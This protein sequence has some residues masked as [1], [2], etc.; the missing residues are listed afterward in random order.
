MKS[1]DTRRK[2]GQNYL[3]DADILATVIRW[4]LANSPL[5]PQSVSALKKRFKL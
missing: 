2:F 4:V 3:K 1:R 5:S